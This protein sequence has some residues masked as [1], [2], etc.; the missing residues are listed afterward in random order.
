MRI[1]TVLLFLNCYA[2][3]LCQ[4]NLVQNGDFETQVGTVDC[5][6]FD[7]QDGQAACEAYWDQTPP[8]TVPEKKSL[9]VHSGSVGSSD[10]YCPGGNF[11]PTYGYMLNR[12]YIS[13]P[14]Q[15][16]LESGKTYLVEFFIKL[17]E[18]GPAYLSNAGIRFSN[19]R[20]KQC[21]F[22][23]LN[24]DGDPHVEIDNNIL[25]YNN[26]WTQVT[27]FYVPDQNYSW[28]TI[29]THNRNEDDVQGF[30]IDDIKIVEWV[31]YC[32]IV[33]LL[34][35]W[36]YGGFST[37]HIINA[38]D[39]LYAGYDV[40][41]PSRS[42]NVVVP[43][44]AYIGFKAGNEVGLFNGFEA[45][46]GSEFRA[47]NA[48]CG[49]ECFTPSPVGGT[50]TVIC[51][52]SP[53]QIGGGAVSGYSYVWVSDP[54]NAIGYL[55]STTISDPIF[56]PPPGEGDVTYYVMATNTCGEMGSNAVSI[57][58]DNTPSSVAQF[59]VNNLQLGDMPTFDLVLNPDIELVII[60]VLDASLN[61]IYYQENFHH[62]IDFQ[63][64][65]LQWGL[66]VV[67]SPCIDYKIRVTVTN[68]CT[69]A[70][71]VQIIDWNRN[72][73]FSLLAPIPN[74]ITPND[75]GINDRVGVSFTGASQI[76]FEV[77]A[78]SGV[79]V[80]YD[81]ITVY[82]TFAWVWDGECNQ[83]L[84]NC[85]NGPLEDGT[86][87]YILKFFDCSG[88]SHDYTGFITLLNG[89]MRMQQQDT[90]ASIAVGN[91]KLFPN[92]TSGNLTIYTGRISEENT[93]L[94]IYNS[95]GQIIEVEDLQV[96]Q[97]NVELDLSY[98]ATGIYY[99]NFLLNGEMQ[100]LRF[101]IEKT[102]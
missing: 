51:D 83:G 42:G 60:E 45:Q 91:P 73:T 2:V 48:P 43:Q 50:S 86:Y 27:V 40:G 30:C 87:F 20:P 38:D 25:F 49:S 100:S 37:G 79:T 13:A 84:P 1:L 65:L 46:F 41:I 90:A 92:P 97:D 74:V 61:T 94:V 11:G 102:E 4:T 14:L 31:P 101:V 32:P 96:G 3:A 77:H 95:M 44:G 56:T 54:Q 12:E 59:S 81:L 85:I 33:Q 70:T 29:G 66:P 36:N 10:H 35:N 7:R 24:I 19:E 72:R 22:E 18:E 80:F 89:G 23:R 47:Y 9:C 39:K 28:L 93:S 98:A 67:L 52:G 34:E 17:K 16:S 26:V 71:S 58:Y 76:S 68:Y 63:C 53:Y 15:S 75:D 88:T 78:S 55:S 6:Y 57:H 21:G 69:G 82:P 8:W 5:D 62:L 99:A 64:C